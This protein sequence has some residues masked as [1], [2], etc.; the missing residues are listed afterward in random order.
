MAHSWR[1]HGYTAL[2]ILHFCFDDGLENNFTHY[3]LKTTLNNVNDRSHSQAKYNILSFGLPLSQRG[4]ACG[5]HKNYRKDKTS[6]PTSP[7]P[8]LYG[9]SLEFLLWKFL[10]P[11]SKTITSL[12]ST[13]SWNKLK[14]RCKSQHDGYQKMSFNM[15]NPCLDAW[16][17]M[18]V[19]C[20]WL[21]K[22]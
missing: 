17:S 11:F 18:R 21:W 16:F 7:F 19:K 1:A 3:T 2:N 22:S 10:L 5:S 12:I 6:E 20:T 14:G 9:D 4:K 13:Y 15:I 8:T